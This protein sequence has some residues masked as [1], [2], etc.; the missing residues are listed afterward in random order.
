[1]IVFTNEYG[2][3]SGLTSYE[4]NEPEMCFCALSMLTVMPTCFVALLAPVQHAIQSSDRLMNKQGTPA[5][6]TNT[7]DPASKFC[8][9]MFIIV[10]PNCGPLAGEKAVM[11][12]S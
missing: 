5:T 10:P 8:P 3:T 2:A 6:S 7:F 12:G 1:M 4:N 9:V 11:R